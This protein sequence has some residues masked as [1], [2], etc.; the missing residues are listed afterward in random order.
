MALWIASNN[1]LWLRKEDKFFSFNSKK[2]YLA[3]PYDVIEDDYGSLVAVQRGNNES[4]EKE[5]IEV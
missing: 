4:V 2:A 3:T 1:G 5:L